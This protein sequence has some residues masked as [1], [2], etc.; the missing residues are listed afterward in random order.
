MSANPQVVIHLLT[1]KCGHSLDAVR[2]RDEMKL[3][4]RIASILQEFELRQL[5]IEEVEKLEVVEEEDHE[6][7]PEE[8]CVGVTT[9]LTSEGT[10]TFSGGQIVSE[11]KFGYARIAIL[12]KFE[13]WIKRTVSRFQ[14]WVAAGYHWAGTV[15]QSRSRESTS[16]CFRFL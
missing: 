14:A 3:A 6:F 15:K 2:S 10:I 11:E 8:D 13:N 12:Y 9:P 4:E 5:Q 16:H 7:R 1:L